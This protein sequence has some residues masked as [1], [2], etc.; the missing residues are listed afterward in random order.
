M[1]VPGRF[2][3]KPMASKDPTVHCDPCVSD[4]R[5]ET[6]EGY[7]R[8]CKE[9]LCPTC[10]S[11]HRK[12]RMTKSHTILQ[13]FDIPIKTLCEPYYGILCAQT[14]KLHTGHNYGRGPCTVIDHCELSSTKKE[15]ETHLCYLEQQ[16]KEHRKQDEDVHLIALS[17]IRQF[18][19][20]VNKYLDEKAKNLTEKANQ[21][22][23]KDENCL[24]DTE[25]RQEQLHLHFVEMHKMVQVQYNEVTKLF[26]DAKCTQKTERR[27][28]LFFSNIYDYYFNALQKLKDL[29][30][31]LSF[32]EICE[33]S[34]DEKINILHS[35]D[36]FSACITGLC[37]LPPDRLLAADHKN[38]SLKL[39]D[40]SNQK[41]TSILKF[42]SSP[43]DVTR[44]PGDRAAAV[45]PMEKRVIVVSTCGELSTVRDIKVSAECNGI[46]YCEGKMLVTYT[47]PGKLEMIGLNEIVFTTVTTDNK[48][49]KVLGNPLY[50]TKQ[51]TSTKRYI[52]VS[53]VK[54]DIV[55][56]L[57]MEGEL[58][59][60]FQDQKLFSFRGLVAVG[61][62]RIALCINDSHKI[63][64]IGDKCGKMVTLS[65][66]DCVR[67]PLAIEYSPQEK[68]LYVS[69]D[70]ANEQNFIHVYDL[71]K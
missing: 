14:N 17:Y 15:I 42:K 19:V 60:Q 32:G 24:Q 70:R 18:R 1:E 48:G 56:K 6:A 44:L 66:M 30:Y 16:M 51:D 20:E 11:F 12:F 13:G 69:S 35:N 55:T 49:N 65:E 59:S 58:V 28:A 71:P 40:I 45:L 4:G 36:A 23:Q 61:D 43:S 62:N 2:E 57:S 47:K 21:L 29:V 67:N 22:A 63:L 10:I 33:A 3:R 5:Q 38:K 64:L 50:V 41:I 53:D 39:V 68:K 27:M 34:V 9:Y 25:D 52:Y 8:M 54:K 37:F 46:C 7:C 26:I 31:E